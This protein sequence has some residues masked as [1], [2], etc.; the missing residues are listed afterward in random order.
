MNKEK[1]QINHVGIIIDGNRRYAKNKGMAT[2]KGHSEGAEKVSKTIEW[3]KDLEIKELTIYTLSTENLKR[4]P[5]ELEHLFNLFKKFFKKFKENKEVHEN[6]VKI[7]FIGD[8]SLVPKD[9]QELIKEIENDTKDY[10]NYKINFCFAYGGRLEL[11]KSINKLI[12]QG[13]PVTE[14]DITNF[15]WLS[16]EPDFIIRT[17]GKTRTSNFLPWQSVYS[18]W[19]FLEKMWPEFEEQDLK[20]CIE[21]FNQTQRNFG[22]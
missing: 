13:K 14:Q 16:S 18:E 20:D 7:K 21:K 12:K 5:K 22:K 11:T 15:L 6:K 9:I 2:H 4:E 17:G 3:C 10:D 1:K 8:I 19:I